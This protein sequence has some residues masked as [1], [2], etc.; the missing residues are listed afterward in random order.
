MNKLQIEYVPIGSVHLNPDNP[1]RNDENV[2]AVV[3]SMTAFEDR[4]PIIV[5][6]ANKMII[7]GH[8]RYKAWTLL[9][10]KEIPVLWWDA[11]EMDA[12]V[13]N[14]FDNKASENSQWDFGKLGD[15]FVEFN[16]QNV[17]LEM[18]GFSSQEIDNIIT[19]PN[20]SPDDAEQ[21]RLD[22]L[23]PKMVKCPKCG[24]EF[25]ARKSEC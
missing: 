2:E 17:D 24:E 1:R 25:D 13:F 14:I 21:P 7:A 8:T 19:G 9:G 12:A 16:Q 5:R 20:F 3:K 15:Y 22:E 6:R 10:R 4:W 23:D 11:N 18:T